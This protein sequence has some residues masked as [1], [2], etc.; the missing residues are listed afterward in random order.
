MYNESMM[1]DNARRGRL[2]YQRLPADQQAGNCQECNEC[3][4]ACP[5]QIP[6]VKWLKKA[7]DWLGPKKKQ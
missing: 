5:Q 4:E 1:Y 2:F 7:H 3:E 6:I